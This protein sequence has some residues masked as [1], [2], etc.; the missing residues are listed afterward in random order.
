MNTQLI[1]NKLREN[2]EFLKDEYGF[3]TVSDVID[4]DFCTIKMQNDTTGVSLN[5]ETREDDVIVYLYRLIE[6]KMIEDKIPVSE[7]IKLNSIE[8][9]FIIQFKKD[10]NSISTFQSQN[11]KSI[12]ELIQNIVSDLKKYADDILKGDFDVFNKVDAIA[13]RRRLEWQN[14]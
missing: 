4:K 9:R 2:F 7:N 8:L 1:A 14:S 6:G 10:D 11:S 3:K 5:Y 13:K 12:D